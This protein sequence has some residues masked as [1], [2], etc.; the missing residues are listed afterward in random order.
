MVYN[1]TSNDYKNPYNSCTIYIAL[2]VIAF[3]RIFSISSAFYLF[4]L[5]L[6]KG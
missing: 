6:K 2:F 5:V 4:S 1:G 3:L